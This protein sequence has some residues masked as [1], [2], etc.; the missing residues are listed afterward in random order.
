MGQIGDR[1]PDFMRYSEL[2]KSNDRVQHLLC[3]FFKDIL[4]FHVTALNFFNLKSKHSQ[5]VTM[6]EVKYAGMMTPLAEWSLFFESLWPKYG[7][8][9][10]IIVAN[11]E[12]HSSLMIGEV[13]LIDIANAQEA[14]ELAAAKYARD[15]EFQ[16]CQDFAFAM[17][18]LSPTL[19][20]NELEAIRKIRCRQSGVWLER[21]EKFRE[22]LDPKGQSRFFWLH[23]IPG[24]GM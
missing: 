20:D 15:E 2:F 24:A 16:R 3:F 7:N 12:R 13:T 23:G 8:R 21:H 19:Y 6:Y 17:Q 11:I 4:D 9:I 1:L 5:M 22:W 10:T 14:R 18:A